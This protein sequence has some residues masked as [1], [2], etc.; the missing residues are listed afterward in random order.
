MSLWKRIQ[1]A[2]EGPPTNRAV[3]PTPPMPAA[4]PAR[5]PREAKLLEPNVGVGWENPEV[6]ESWD[7]PV[8]VVA[9]ESHH[10]AELRSLTGPPIEN[11][12]AVPVP[13][14]LILEPTNQYD[15][16]AV[17]VEIRGLLV[18]YINGKDAPAVG[19]RMRSVGV[20]RITL[21]GLLKGGALN[22]Q[23]VG[24][25]IWPTK[26]LTAAPSLS[27]RIPGRVNPRQR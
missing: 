16:N 23:F 18:G 4:T 15:P 8:S 21:A 1:Q 10:A 27:F 6:Y 26:R 3:P 11:G 2:V 20:D 19:S 14:E 5:K 7:W 17:R 24:V 22:M 9:G 12:Y 25:L 13:V